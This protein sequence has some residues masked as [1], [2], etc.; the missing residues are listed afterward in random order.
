MQE[1]RYAHILCLERE[2]ELIENARK[3]GTET[4]GYT[5][6]DWQKEIANNFEHFKK[7]IK[8]S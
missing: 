6:E 1:I 8:T 7:H 5:E 3:H 2:K 4:H